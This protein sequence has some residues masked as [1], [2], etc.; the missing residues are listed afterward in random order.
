MS[1][2]F[3]S[4]SS[5]FID[6]NKQLTTRHERGGKYGKKDRRLRRQEVYKLHF[7]YGY[8]ALK[9]AEMMKFNRHTIEDDIKFWYSKLEKQWEDIS[10]E[11]QLQKQINR[12]E[13]QRSRLVEELEKQKDNLENKIQ[14]EKLIMQIDARISKITMKAHKTQDVFVS[15]AVEA[16]NELAEEHKLDWRLHNPS[17]TFRISK[18]KHEA[19]KKILAK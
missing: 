10:Y 3:V 8:S 18:S 11:A 4:I 16:F 12:L 9:I 13:L 15:A 7:E 6:E 1:N 2:E 17:N 19:I 5:D 14:I